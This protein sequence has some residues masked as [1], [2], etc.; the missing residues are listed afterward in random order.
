MDYRITR[1]ARRDVLD[2]WKYVARDGESAADRFIDRLTHRFRILGD[3]PHA[4]RARDEI[5]PGYAAS[6]WANIRFSTARASPES[7]S[8]TSSTDAAT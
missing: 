1:R 5:R 6:R 4:G 2:L 8:C 3:V 7:K